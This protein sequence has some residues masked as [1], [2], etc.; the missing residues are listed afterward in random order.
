MKICKVCKKE[1]PEDS[2]YLN[3]G[4]YRLHTCKYCLSKRETTRT[5]QKRKIKFSRAWF[6]RRFCRVKRNAK[7][8]NKK[9]ELTFEEF[10]RIRT[11]KNEKCFYCGTTRG[12]FSIE[13]LDNVKGY[14]VSN[15]VVACWRCN[16]MKSKDFTMEEMKIL[17]RALRKIDKL[18]NT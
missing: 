1:L 4:K 5:L 11:Y 14:S 9:F 3:R 18:R 7:D 17:G 2:F 16:K 10:C 12:P 13:R 15:C 6:R 8:K